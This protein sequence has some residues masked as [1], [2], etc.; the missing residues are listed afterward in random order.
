MLLVHDEEADADE[1]R[2]DAS[3]PHIGRGVGQQR[4]AERLHHEEEGQEEGDE[5]AE[6]GVEA[7]EYSLDGGE[8]LAYE[9]PVEIAEPGEHTVA[10]APAGEHDDVPEISFTLAG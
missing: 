10:Y 2:R 3:S 9:A 5:P 4:H 7:I 6:D 1:P 8:W